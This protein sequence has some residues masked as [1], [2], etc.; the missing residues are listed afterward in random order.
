MPQTAKTTTTC[1]YA[2]LRTD[3]LGGG[4]MTVTR[5]LCLVESHM[6]DA[7]ARRERSLFT[8]LTFC[9]VIGSCYLRLNENTHLYPLFRVSFTRVI[10]YYQLA[11]LE[12]F[13]SSVI[14]LQKF[15]PVRTLSHD[16]IFKPRSHVRTFPHSQRLLL[17]I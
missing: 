4:A 12:L 6:L 1:K 14:P 17:T 2:T 9:K 7:A 15:L 11:L 10:C 13:T 8:L 3:T 16:H 5:P